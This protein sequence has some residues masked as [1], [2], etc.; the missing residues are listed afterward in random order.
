M[1]PRPN[2]AAPAGWILYDGDCGFCRKWVR[3]FAG[4][5]GRRGFGVAPLQSDWVRAELQLSE[6]ELVRDFRL[7]RANGTQLC[8]AEV[9]RAIT[10]QI[11]WAWPVYLF[12]ITPGL[13]GVFDWGYRTFAAN[14]HRLSSTCGLNNRPD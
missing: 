12:S 4:V 2:S 3:R 11:W 8:G 6:A 5:L 10:R 14:R 13:R 1:N 9:Y 7:L